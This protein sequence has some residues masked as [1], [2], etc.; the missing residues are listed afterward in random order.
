LRT[1]PEVTPDIAARVNNAETHMEEGKAL[2]E[3]A[4]AR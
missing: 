1:L 2:H 4:P 3:D